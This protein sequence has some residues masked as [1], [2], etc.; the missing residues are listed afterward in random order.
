MTPIHTIL[1]PVD[2]SPLS[3]SEVGLAAELAQA[4]GARRVLTAGPIALGIERLAR[5][6]TADLVVLAC[7]GG[8]TDDRSSMTEVLLHSCTCPILTLHEGA[9]R[10]RVLRLARRSGRPLRVLVPMDLSAGG[11]AAV[12]YALDLAVALAPEAGVRI[13]LLHVAE[14]GR[15]RARPHRDR[16]ARP[17]PLG[18]PLHPRRRPGGPP[19][20]PLPGLVR[21]PAA[22]GGVSG[23]GLALHLKPRAVVGRGR[24]SG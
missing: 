18:P 24:G 15:A 19:P 14:G 9:D 6:V 4:L 21:A 7:H 11:A 10:E 23:T 3:A 8:T 17:R 2:L 22:A 1:C 13:E 5:E 20:R 16:G 12:G